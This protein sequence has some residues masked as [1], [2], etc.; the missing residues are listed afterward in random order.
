MYVL[1]VCVCVG[2]SMCICLLGMSVG[3]I[4][5][6]IRISQWKNISMYI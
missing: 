2:L 5:V 6:P 4:R 1:C 3:D